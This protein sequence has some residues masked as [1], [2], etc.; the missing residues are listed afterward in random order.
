MLIGDQYFR[1]EPYAIAVCNSE[2]ERG[3]FSGFKKYTVCDWSVSGQ[4]QKFSFNGKH[5]GKRYWR[6]EWHDRHYVIG[7][8][9][10]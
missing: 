10:M 7:D 5:A 4:F 8:I 2:S 9:N 6:E 3:H 1:C